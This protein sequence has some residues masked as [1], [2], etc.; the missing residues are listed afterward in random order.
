MVEREMR[1]QMATDIAQFL[2]NWNELEVA[3]IMMIEGDVADRKPAP[4]HILMSNLFDKRKM[5]QEY[6]D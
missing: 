2:Q 1:L 3:C 4:S 5:I 6:N